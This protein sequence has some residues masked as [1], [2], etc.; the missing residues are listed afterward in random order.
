MKKEDIVEMMAR[1][2]HNAY[3]KIYSL[4]TWAEMVKRAKKGCEG[5]DI[6]LKNVRA[7]QRVSLSAL[8]KKGIFLLDG[9]PDYDS[10][11]ETNRLTDEEARGWDSCVSTIRQRIR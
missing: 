8:R 3:A 6:L 1:I 9:I 11:A 7:S 4:P 10:D 5:S 2:N